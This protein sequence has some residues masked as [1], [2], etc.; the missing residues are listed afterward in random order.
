MITRHRLDVTALGARGDGTAHF[1][2]QSV[3]VPGALP[4][5]TVEA[6][7]DHGQAFD[8]E[9]IARSAERS[10]PPFRHFPACGGCVIQHAAPDLYAAWK[11][12]LV[13]DALKR[14][15]I[16]APVGDPVPCAPA[17]RRRA[18]FSVLNTADGVL[19]GF[20]RRGTNTIEPVEMCEIVMPVL[21]QARAALKA[22]ARALLPLMAGKAKP[23][24]LT[25]T[26]TRSGLDVAFKGVPDLNEERRQAAIRIAEKAGLARLSTDGEIIVEA[27]KPVVMI[28]GMAVE[29]PPGGFLQAVEATETAMRRVAV[30]H[31]L[32]AKR[33]ADLFCGV[34]TFALPLARFSTV[35][36]VESDAASLASLDRAWRRAAPLERLRDVTSEKRDLFI[37]PVTA[38]ELTGVDGVVFDP[39]RAGAEA[40]ARE[41][42]MSRVGRVAAVSCNPVTLARDLAILIG[43]GYRIMSVTP[44]DQ[45]L[46][47]HH[48]E[49]VALLEKR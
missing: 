44:F 5:E 48:V 47:S 11:R 38:R 22:Q 46:W 4:G 21:N 29:L 27:R 31:L 23:A 20:Q 9:V 18:T 2:G 12:S 28:D 24:Q 33:T 13:V 39:P 42:A 25:V 43:G 14:E 16:E 35:H 8:V 30:G 19:F 37:R 3:H 10:V 15:R 32:G 34:G 6:S 41:L 7:I 26:V 40:Q 49:A 45:F 36:A 17:S 1:E